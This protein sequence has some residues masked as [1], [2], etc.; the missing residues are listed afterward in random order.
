M[1]NEKKELQQLI[2]RIKLELKHANRGKWLTLAAFLFRN[3]GCQKQLGALSLG[4]FQDLEGHWRKLS[5][6]LPRVSSVRRTQTLSWRRTLTSQ[7]NK[8]FKYVASSQINSVDKHG[9]QLVKRA[10]A[11]TAKEK[12]RRKALSQQSQSNHHAAQKGNHRH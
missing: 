9:E 10:Q 4:Q 6:S 2:E 3:K 12:R 11:E 7:K 1:Q 8:F 5:P